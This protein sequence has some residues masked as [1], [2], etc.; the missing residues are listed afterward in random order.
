MSVCRSTTLVQTEIS[1]ITTGSITMKFSSYIYVF[2][3]IGD[4]IVL[5]IAPSPGQNLALSN[6]LVYDRIPAKLM[7]LPL[8][9]V[10]ISKCEH[11]QLRW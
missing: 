9:A 8:R 4:P 10:P 2:F 6:T 11:A 7:S 5:S 3:R 1:N